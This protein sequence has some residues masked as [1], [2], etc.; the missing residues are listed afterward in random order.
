MFYIKGNWL[1]RAISL[2]LITTIQVGGI[3]IIGIMIFL[4]RCADNKCNTGIEW[5]D[6]I[7]LLTFIILYIWGL[8]FAM[9]SIVSFI[10]KRLNKK[11]ILMEYHSVY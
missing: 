7:L 3:I 9:I 2:L 1:V 6:I 5:S 8:K 10:N 4:P 11:I